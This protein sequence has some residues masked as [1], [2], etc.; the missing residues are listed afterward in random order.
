MAQRSPFAS[1]LALLIRDGCAPLRV[2]LTFSLP[3][4]L[5]AEYV[6]Y[7]YYGP[8]DFGAAFR[9]SALVG[10]LMLPVCAIAI[11]RAA[12]DRAS[13]I[14]LSYSDLLRSSVSGWAHVFKARFLAA[15]LVTL[16]M[17][18]LL[19]PGVLL[20]IRYAFVEVLAIEE[21]A[22]G[23]EA[24]KRSAE[25]AKGRSWVVFRLLASVFGAVVAA[26]VVVSA[27]LGIW[28]EA[29]NFVFAALGDAAFDVLLSAAYGGAWFIYATGEPEAGPDLP[30]PI[31]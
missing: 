8:D 20:A 13:S 18:A 4:N 3:V 17:L 24:R 11:V 29:D 21:G 16:G 6:I 25:L 7:T 5:V 26:A 27:P 2:I 14:R 10:S 31:A 28:P 1:S 9:I 30:E 22:R 23:G 12:S 19:V 15:V